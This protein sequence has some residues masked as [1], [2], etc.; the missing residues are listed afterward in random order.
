MKIIA[1]YNIKGGVGKTATSV[2]LAYLAA[3]EGRQVLLWDLDPQGASSF[4]FRTRPRV[5]GGVTKLLQKKKHFGDHIKGTDFEN[6]DIL[7]ADFSYRHMDLELEDTGKPTRRLR[8]LL[9]TQREDYDLVVLDCPPSISLV[10]ENVFTSADA[11]LIPT[12][13]TTLSLRTLEQIYRYREDNRLQEVQLLPF[14]S[15]VDRRK[16]LH[17]LITDNPPRKFRGLLH[18][19]IPYASEVER[20]GTKRLPLPVYCHRGAALAAYHALWHEV[21]QQ[22]SL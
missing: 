18:S 19:A 8:Q 5:K 12:I 20:M 9:K 14:F 22:L 15:M 6:L 16:S 2:N 4:Y 21:K 3:R 7:P 11:L 10:S 1:L 17:R 13:P